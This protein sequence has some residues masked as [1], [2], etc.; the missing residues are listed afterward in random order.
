MPTLVSLLAAGTQEQ[1]YS[2]GSPEVEGALTL[3]MPL[4]IHPWYLFRDCS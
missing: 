1:G 2:E 4:T 3:K